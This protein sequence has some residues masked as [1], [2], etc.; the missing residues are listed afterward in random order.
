RPAVR[1]PYVPEDETE[2]WA[3]VFV[4]DIYRGL[5][6]HVKRGEIKKIAVVQ[7]IRRSLINSPGIHK[8]AF[9]FQRIVV[10]CG[11][12]YVPKKVWGYA[13]V[14]EDGSACFKV[15]ARQPIYFMAL[16]AQGRAVQRM[17]SF[18][19]LM[20]GEV[21][22]CVGCHESRRQGPLPGPLVRSLVRDPQELV[23]PEWG[24]LGF[25]YS[26]VVQ[27]VLDKNCV[28]C[29]NPYGLQAAPPTVAAAVASGVSLKEGVAPGDSQPRPL[30]TRLVMLDVPPAPPKG[31]DLTGDRTDFFNMSYEVLARKDQGRTGSPYIRWIPSYNGHEWNI[32]ESWPV[33]PTRRASRA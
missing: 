33:T 31:I 24:V 15:P 16:D 19:H 27:P 3:T 18:T 11:A 20:P 4:Q 30:E 2:P 29:H 6:P 8:P 14:A 12:T 25:D 32:L 10:S 22:G 17:R 23:P 1:A 9:G 28:H 21:Q 13:D 26:L 7:E 5:E